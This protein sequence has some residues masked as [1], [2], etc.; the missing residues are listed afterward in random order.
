MTA[1]ATVQ[2]ALPARRDWKRTSTIETRMQ[3]LVLLDIAGYHPHNSLAH[4][5]P[6]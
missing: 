4:A 6:S 3:S 1:L 5:A 2:R